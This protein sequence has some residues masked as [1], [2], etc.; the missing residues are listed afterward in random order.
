MTL[1]MALLIAILRKEAL[2]PKHTVAF[3]ATQLLP[4]IKEASTWPSRGNDF[5]RRELLVRPC[6]ALLLLPACSNRLTREPSTTPPLPLQQRRLLIGVP[7]AMSAISAFVSGDVLFPG[8]QLSVACAAR[9][10]KLAEHGSTHGVHHCL[11]RSIPVSFPSA[12]SLIVLGTLLMTSGAHTT[13]CRSCGA[14]LKRRQPCTVSSGRR[15]VVPDHFMRVQPDGFT[16]QASPNLLLRAHQASR[17]TRMTRASWMWCAH[18]R[19]GVTCSSPTPAS[20][21]PGS[22]TAMT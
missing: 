13:R 14:H 17:A 7:I 6:T 15:L 8:G 1:P 19:R 3:A 18:M 2:L 22:M 20:V 4:V 12:V 5:F 11:S 16:R 10:S 9:A 21:A